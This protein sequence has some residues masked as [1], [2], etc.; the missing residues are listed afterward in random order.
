MLRK[1][2]LQ[3]NAIIDIPWVVRKM[4]NNAHPDLDISKV[5]GT[6]FHIGIN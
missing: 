2:L 6:V 1:F 4:M 3:S 5:Q